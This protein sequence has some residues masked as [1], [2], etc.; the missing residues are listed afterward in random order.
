MVKGKE[1]VEA[2][3][4][5]E[6]VDE[7]HIGNWMVVSHLNENK[8]Y[9]TY[10]ETTQIVIEI[11]EIWWFIH[12]TNISDNRVNWEAKDHKEIAPRIH[13]LQL[14]KLLKKGFSMNHFLSRVEGFRTHS[15]ENAAK[16]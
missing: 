11:E 6:K 3:K 13:S 8:H 12:W 2:K 16:K 15:N 10:H 14:K 7:K 9:F 1:Q 4:E 5:R